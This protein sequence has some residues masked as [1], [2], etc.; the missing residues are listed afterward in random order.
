MESGK[1]ALLTLFDM[2]AAFDTV[3][4]E[5][6]LLRLDATYGIR[7][8]ALMWI[9]SYFSDRTEKVHVMYVPLKYGISQGVATIHYVHW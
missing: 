8:G 9:A 7:N 6:L 5:I 4:Q 1:L 2:S 3:D